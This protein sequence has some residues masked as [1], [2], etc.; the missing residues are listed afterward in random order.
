MLAKVGQTNVIATDNNPGLTS[1]QAA[2][3]NS[4]RSF[5]QYDYQTE[6]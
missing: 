5:H 6:N 1:G 3:T 4:I 2:H